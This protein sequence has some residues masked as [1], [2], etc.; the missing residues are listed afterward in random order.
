MEAFKRG[1]RFDKHYLR[2][3]L[4]G[5]V[6]PDRLEDYAPRKYGQRIK[7]IQDDEY[8]VGDTVGGVAAL[9]V[10]DEGFDLLLID[11]DPTTF[12]GVARHLQ[13][14]LTKYTIVLAI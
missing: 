14:T 11:R 8:G 2:F 9:G 5:Y 6:R 1:M 13:G 7:E 12:R 3:L 10:Q 4:Y